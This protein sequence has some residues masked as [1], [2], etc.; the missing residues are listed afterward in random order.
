[1]YLIE[2][3]MDEH[4]ERWRGISTSGDKILL[5]CFIPGLAGLSPASWLD[6]IPPMDNPCT[7]VYGTDVAMRLLAHIVDG[8]AHR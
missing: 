8:K 4:L 3:I 6:C 2:N 5:V 7:R 1:M